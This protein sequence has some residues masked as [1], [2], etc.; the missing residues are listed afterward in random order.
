MS[1]CILK[2]IAAL[3][4][5]ID[6][7]GLL[8]FPGAHWM[9]IA[10]R[11]A[12]PIYAYFIAEGFRYTRS[13]KRYFL[14]IFL[15]GL[16]CQTVYTI[17]DRTLY[18]GILLTFSFSIL[19]MWLTDAARRAFREHTPDRYLRAAAAAAATLA[20]ALLCHFVT[21]D[22]GFFGILTPVLASLFDD[23]PSR[24][25]A[26]SLGLAAVA[27]AE[28]LGGNTT[29]LASAFAVPLLALYNGKP[30]RYRLK[31]FFY[32]FY[33][34]HLALLQLIAWLLPARG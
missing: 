3:S 15:L 14:R 26:L 19:L 2:L 6:H 10:G 23:K 18:L 9:R 21:V 31:T 8:L 5:L 4:M 20:A 1:G 33:P 7:A 16:A 34:T 25:A 28:L 30:G 27:T 32:L 11:L 17:A 12:F 29:Q 22:Y 24:I 13:R